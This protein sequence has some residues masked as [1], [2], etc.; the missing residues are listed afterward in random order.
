MSYDLGT[1]HGKIEIDYDGDGATAKAD[2]DIRKVGDSSDKS[3]KK[4]SKF[5]ESLSKFSGVLNKMAKG[6]A[7]GALGIS[8]MVHAVGLLAGTLA[9]LAPLAVAALGTLPGIIAG[10]V[11]AM[12]VFKVATMG[13]GDALKAAGGDADKFNKALEKLSP[14]AR[15]FAVAW[16]DAGKALKPMQQAMQDALFAGLA[17]QVKRIATGVS[18]LRGAAVGVAS[19][20]NALAKEALG[21][22]KDVQFEQLETVLRGV[23]TFLGRIKGSIKPVIQGFLDLAAQAS[24]FSGTLGSGVAGALQKLGAAMKGFDLKKAFDDAMVVLRPLGE[25]L[26]SVGRILKA[27]FGGLQT[28]AGGAL[29]VVGELAGKLADFL[30]SAQGQE[31]LQAL[32]QAMQTISG[33][34]GQV[35]LTLLQQLA[36]VIVALAPGLAELALQVASVLVPALEA[37]G[38]ALTAVAGFL[39]DNMDVIGPL[40]IAVYGLVGAYKAYSAAAD[41][42]KAVQGALNGKLGETIA[43]WGKNAAAV[44]A[45]TAKHVAH[46]AV[47]T[48]QAIAGMARNTAAWVANTASIVANKVALAASA[49]AGWIANTA[50]VVKNTAALVAQK[51]IQGAILVATKAWTA[52][53]W[54]LNVALNANPIGLIV[55]AIVALIAIIVL[56]ATKTTWFQTIWKVVWTAIKDAAKAVADWF[57]N[58]LV[59]S[60]KKAWDQLRAVVKFVVDLVIGYFNFW[61]SVW[62]A[63]FNAIVA[64]A[65]AWWN[66]VKAIFN[67]I[68]AVLDKVAGFFKSLKDSIVA[69]LGEAVSFVK[70]IPGKLLSALGNLGNKLYEK[71]K[72]FVRGFIDGIGSM[73]GAAVNKVKGLVNAVTDWLPGSPAKKGPLSG[74]GWTPYRGKALVEGF[75]AGMEKQ[76]GLVQNLSTKIAVAAVPVVPTALGGASLA[77]AGAP[78]ATLTRPAPA[79]E[80]GGNITIASLS[81][82]V[83]GVLDM[84]DPQAARQIATKIHGAIE[85][86][87]KGYR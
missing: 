41:G 56:I 15:A 37:A 73:V 44:A 57:M 45:S 18:S 23:S 65:R 35:F 7:V 55:I 27:V 61:K 49:A 77:G 54:L 62:Q 53:Q 32:G 79:P 66:G 39:S 46:G 83:Q 52:A 58:T 76:I 71:G 43:T 20:F 29:G 3:D 40:V 6:A 26:S 51:A 21:S 64:A 16:R 63:V 68:K 47:V 69:R 14:Q 42:V 28:D 33:A 22:I 50:A 67:G 84:A 80:G 1:A 2:E 19:A 82:T 10:G 36:P 12:A 75:A 30:E 78:V 9:A 85:D 74:R 38:P 48:G 86:L 25:L 87:K 11:A 70:G 31:A 34:A 13:V 8:T 4:V 60:F 72:E 5:G 81:V 17:P 59:P 24:A